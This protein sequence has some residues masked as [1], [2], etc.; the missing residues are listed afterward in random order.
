MASTV[1]SYKRSLSVV[2]DKYRDQ[3]VKCPCYGE[4]FV[5]SEEL[6]TLEYASDKP[7]ACDYRQS[8]NENKPFTLIESFGN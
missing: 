1:T 3:S 7:C 5:A 8:P 4:M 6:E 2:D